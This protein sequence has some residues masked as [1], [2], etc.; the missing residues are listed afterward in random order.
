MTEHQNFKQK[1]AKAAKVLDDCLILSSF[2]LLPSAK[3]I[4]ACEN[5]SDESAGNSIGIFSTTTSPA[6]L[7]SH[8]HPKFKI[9]DEWSRK[10]IG[11][12]IE[13]HRDKGPGL[14]ESIYEKCLMRELSLQNILARQQLIVRVEYKGFVFEEPLKVDVYVEDCL[15]V[16]LKAVEKILP[17]HKAQLLSYMKLLDSPLGLLI[18]FHETRLVDGVHR[19]ILP[20][21]DGSGFGAKQPGGDF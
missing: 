9:A 1:E 11:A 16:E 5:P 18:N 14:I 13:V 4:L 21:A 20:G 15:I 7:R 3:S 12:A 8:M 17:I 6:P 2:P 19:L 10:V